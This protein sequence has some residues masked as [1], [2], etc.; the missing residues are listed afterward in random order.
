MDPS[1]SAAA[2]AQASV[3]AHRAL[4]MAREMG[5]PLKPAGKMHDLAGE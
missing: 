5:L 2:A 4:R 3:G 1:C